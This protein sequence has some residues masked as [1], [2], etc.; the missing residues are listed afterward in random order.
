MKSFDFL[1]RLLIK[2][3]NFMQMNSEFRERQPIGVKNLWAALTRHTIA[4]KTGQ[5]TGAIS[6]F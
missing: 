4:R 2:L 3:L 1:G 5:I 6:L